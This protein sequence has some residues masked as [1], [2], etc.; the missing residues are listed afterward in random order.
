[1][2]YLPSTGTSAHRTHAFADHT[3]TYLE[4]AERQNW[5]VL[6][7]SSRLKTFLDEGWT[8]AT[9]CQRLKDPACTLDSLSTPPSPGPLPR[10]SLSF[11]DNILP[12]FTLDEMHKHIVKFIIAD[13]QVS[14]CTLSTH[15]V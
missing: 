9:M 1:M 10:T 2:S 11:P 13:D 8:V 6:H 4:E 3:D 5:H 15:Y 12:A 14:Q 7:K